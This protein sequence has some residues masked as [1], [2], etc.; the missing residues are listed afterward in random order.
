MVKLGDRRGPPHLDPRSMD[1]AANVATSKSLLALQ[2]QHVSA[3]LGCKEDMLENIKVPL[4]LKLSALWTSLMFCYVYGDYFGLYP[5]GQLKGM[6][7]GNGPI[8]PTSQGSLVAVSLLMIIPSLMSFLPL[9]LAP[10]LNRWLNIA[11]A[12]IYAAVVAL[13]MPGSWA[14]YLM[15]SS[16]EILLCM[17]IAWHAWRWPKVPP[18]SALSR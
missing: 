10:V 1:V 13:T 6:L 8:G 17:L 14:F 7:E 4:R 5:P 12:L 2:P 9:T 16:V 18:T 15:F 11:L 3:V